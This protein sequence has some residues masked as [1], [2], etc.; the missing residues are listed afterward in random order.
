MN[1]FLK[2]GINHWYVVAWIQVSMI[3]CVSAIFLDAWNPIIIS[4]VGFILCLVV[5]YFLERRYYAVK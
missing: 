2:P 4:N 1:K 5:E 3:C